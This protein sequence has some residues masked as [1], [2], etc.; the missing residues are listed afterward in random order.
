[1]LHRWLMR[2][3]I[4]RSPPEDRGQAQ[5]GNDLRPRKLHVRAARAN[6]KNSFGRNQADAPGHP[7]T[8]ARAS[9]CDGSIGKSRQ[10][11]WNQAG[12]EACGKP[13]R[14]LADDAGRRTGSLH[15]IS[16]RGSGA[17]RGSALPRN[18]QEVRAGVPGPFSGIGSDGTGERRCTPR[19]D[20]Y[21]GR[22]QHRDNAAPRR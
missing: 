5:L 22:R 9:S 6:R 21:A 11:T 19:H 7:Q 10:R 14:F 15:A 12:T 8:Y 20:R 16:G 1:M 4:C 18:F 13:S 3:A 17:R 2:T